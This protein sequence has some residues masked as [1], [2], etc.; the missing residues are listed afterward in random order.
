MCGVSEINIKNIILIGY[1]GHAYVCIE[2]ALLN[3][4]EVTG[5]CD[6]EMK[7]LNPYNLPFLGNESNYLN[8]KT[9]ED[10]FVGIGNNGLREKIVDGFSYVRFVNLIHPY[11]AI[12]KTAEI[13][14]DSNVLVNA[15]VVVN[16]LAK[17]GKGVILNTSCIIEHECEVGAFAHIAPGAVLAGN[18]KIGERTFVGANAVIKHGVVIGKDVVVGAGTVVIRDVPDGKIMAGNPAKEIKKHSI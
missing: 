17:I 9:L 2:N 11:S 12:S 10:V 4:F 8:H 5:Y 1:S 3:G 18:V 7:P 6:L 13:P 16:A 14:R 15:G